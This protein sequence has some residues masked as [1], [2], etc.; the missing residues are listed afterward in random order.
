MLLLFILPVLCMCFALGEDTG[1]SPSAEVMEGLDFLSREKIDACLTALN[2]KPNVTVP[3]LLF[4]A[5]K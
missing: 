5:V 2:S 3:L 1:F 4:S